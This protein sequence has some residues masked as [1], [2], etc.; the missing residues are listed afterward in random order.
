MKRKVLRTLVFPVVTG[1]SFL[2]S[3]HRVAAQSCLTTDFNGKVFDL[4]CPQAC[5]TLVG[6]VPHIKSSGD[7]A[8]TSIAHTPYPWSAP[9]GV[10]L[11]ELY[12]D[13]VYSRLINLPFSFCFYGTLYNS[14][15]VGS[16]GIIT[17][18][19]SNAN[20]VNSWSL[21]TVPHG[22]VPQP[23][24]YPFGTPNTTT[25]TYYPPA[26]IMGAYHDIFPVL[27][28]GGQRRIE[29]A[30]IGSAPCRKF[31]VSYY[32]V[33]LYGSTVCNG[34]MCTQQIVLHE[35]TG[36]IDVHLGDKP[37]CNVWNEGLAILGLQNWNRDAA[38]WAPGKNCTVWS[39]TGTSYR[40]TP[41][42]GAS[43]FVRSELYTM[44]G[45]LVATGDTTTTTPGL[46][47]IRFLN[48]CPPPD[49]TRYEVHTTY[50]SCSDP[51]LQLISVDTITTIKDNNLGATASSTNSSCGPPSGTITVTV[52]A[53]A[54]TAPFT[55]VLD[56]GAPFTGGNT[57]TYLNVMH[58]P[59]TVVVTDANG[60]AGCR[61][62]IDI[63]VGRNNGLLANTSTTPAFCAGSAS[64]TITVTL[65]NGSGPY[66]YT[67]NGGLPV[68][69]GSPHTFTGLSAGTHTLIIEDA[70]GCLSDP[71]SINVVNGP[72]ISANYTTTPTT[73]PT[74]SNGTLT[75]T[76]ATGQAPFTFIM[77]GGTPVTGSNPYTFMNLAAG[78]HN[79]LITDNAGCSFPMNADVPSGPALASSNF[80]TATTCNGASDGTITVTPLSGNAPFSFSLDGAPAVPGTPPYTFSNLA[81]VPH[82]IL[83]TDA[84][85]CSTPVYAVTVPAGPDLISSA[86]K[87]D[88]LCNGAATGTITIN[89]PATGQP[90]FQYSIDNLN[91]QSGRFFSGLT[92][93]SYTTYF[94]AS[95]GCRGSYDIT[96]NEPPA[97]SPVITTVPV[98]CNGESNGTINITTTGGA[99]PYQY[100]I[101][102]GA[103]WSA[104]G[105]FQ[106]PASTYTVL[107]RDANNCIVSKSIAVT[108]PA[109]LTAS[110]VNTSATCDGGNNGTIL[111]TATGGNSNYLYSVDGNNFGP[112]RIF[113]V[114]PGSYTVYVKDNLG[115]KTSFPAVVGLNFNLTLTPMADPTI[116]EGSS[117]QLQPASN[118]T[119]YTWTPATGLSDP[120]ISNPV[121]GPKD[122]T[123]YYLTA[124]LGR[125]TL[126]DT[127]RLNVNKAPVPEAGP[128]G[129]I[130]YGQSYTLQG[131]GGT[132][133]TWSPA[134]YLNTTTGANPVSTPT[135][136]TIYY[137]RV[138]DDHGC[139]SLIEDSV[140][141]VVKR[142]MSVHT[143]PFDTVAAPGETFRLL[144]VSPGIS[145]NWTPSTGLSNTNIPDPMVT[146]SN[147][148]GDEMRYQVT[149]TNSDGCKGEGFVKIRISKGPAI[150]VPT[151][152]TPNGDGKN[153]KFTPF[154]VG[155]RTYTYFRVFNRWGQVI[156]S[157]RQMNAGWDGTINGKE[158]PAG[159]YV[160]M[161]E[162]ITSGNQVITKK[163]TVTLIR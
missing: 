12:A 51:G 111:V 7:Y 99:G 91:W 153:D 75:L 163:G 61:S 139:G 151:A 9:G 50:T 5:S 8:V 24:P 26:S 62:T 135:L 17:F 124:T 155:I 142:I 145:Y 119:V 72:G 137:L 55:Y 6:Q 101:D 64:G 115:C 105:T 106:V 68:T 80:A 10:E 59:H 117:I 133:Y 67:L 39:E 152:F 92:A 13:D 53:G 14:L 127:I 16:N 11:T 93:G 78:T 79:I 38:V 122:T 108:Q 88:V 82:T 118:A 107:T 89:V 57:Y 109:V 98:Q 33:P 32:L 138:Q 15:V 87:T 4:V 47:D 58:G 48:F 156:F 44:T 49:T 131:S 56:G 1:L 116:C 63:T 97:I 23:I 2:F 35:S 128:G 146:V 143:F 25:S 86:A 144:A 60:I 31:V 52:P 129:E 83:V 134:I 147:I 154:P 21:T 46:L 95:N 112:S 132:T 123:W 22:V 104:G 160:W 121:A 34:R 3:Y 42:G 29:Y 141:V 100:S 41:S 30:I 110:S 126:Y 36:I 103:T 43:K 149:A 81:S 94:R 148:I 27:N 113:H 150:Y 28:P 66:T 70:T 159:T 69:A 161:I 37:V 76:A 20:K 73:C 40:F 96:I 90:P 114:G 157:T 45:T 102:N 85:G 162:G 71:I 84:T 158:Q 19:V 65:T 54:G 136:S 130:C 140:R 125:C 74:V 120:F 18:D 77:D